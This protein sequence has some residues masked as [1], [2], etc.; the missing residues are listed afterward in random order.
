VRKPQLRKID[1]VKVH[2]DPYRS[3]VQKQ[4]IH[5]YGC[6]SKKYMKLEIQSHDTAKEITNYQP[7]TSINYYKKFEPIHYVNFQKQ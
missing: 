4:N 3:K 5:H 1:S 6:K 7:T 2:V